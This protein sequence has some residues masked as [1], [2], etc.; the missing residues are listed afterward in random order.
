MSLLLGRRPP[1]VPP[2]DPPRAEGTIAVGHRRK[3]GYAEFG[4]PAG[5]LVLWFHGTPGGRRQ[6]PMVGRRAA[7]L[8]GLR[9]VVVERP[10]AGDSTDHR[11]SCIGDWADDI[12]TVA[13]H[14][15][16]DLFAV[17]G[18]SGGGPYAL[19]CGA[20]LNERVIGVGILGGVVPSV[21]PDTS[22]T[23]VVNLARTFQPLLQ[24][25]R[26]PLGTALWAALKP[27]TPFAHP[28]Y[29]AYAHTSP[30]G[31]RIVF[32]DPEIEAMFID[33]IFSA[34][35][36][37]FRAVVND[38]I[39]FGRDWGFRLADV[40]VPVRWWHG[41]SDVIVPLTGAERALARLPRAEL[42]VR[43]GESHLGGFAAADEVL[44]AIDHVWTTH[45]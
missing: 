5:R 35:R 43:P 38:A 6:L 30:P 13:D 45:V 16:H 11:Y 20:R 21:G 4:D 8:L 32:A 44:R 9:V 2:I 28:A 33:D 42:H 34:S 7:E 40:D 1:G 15:G 12:A 26:W 22:A 36:H 39:L 25:T 10:G 29:Q 24:L 14:L 37:Q 27:L 18:L 19:A 3:L 17:V 23:G 31:D 41:D